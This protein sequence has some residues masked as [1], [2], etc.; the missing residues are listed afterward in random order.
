MCEFDFLS[1]TQQVFIEH[2]LDNQA[3]LGVNTIRLILQRYIDDLVR[4]PDTVRAVK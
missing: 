2:L 3:L 4:D 1:F